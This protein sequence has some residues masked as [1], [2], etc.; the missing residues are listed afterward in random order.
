MADLTTAYRNAVANY[1]RGGGAPTA[2]SGIFLDLFNGDPQGAG[3]SVLATLTGS[4]T[5]PNITS[6]I[7]AA[8]GGASTNAA[9]IDVEAA[10]DA[11]A[12]ITHLA[13]Y[14]AATSG[15]LIWSDALTGGN[16]VITTGN[17]IVIP[18]NGLTL[19]VA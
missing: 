4:A 16:Q 5:R 11:G 2:I 9:Q 13:L 17:P 15:N 6:A 7:G 1:L 10:A 8:S 3:S 18:A 14:D 19:T 12:T